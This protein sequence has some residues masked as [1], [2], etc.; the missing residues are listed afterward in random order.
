MIVFSHGNSFP[1]RTYSV[2]IESLR[3]RGFDVRFIEKFGHDPRFP[4]ADNWPATEEELS[5]FVGALVQVRQG[6]PLWLVGHS[7]GGLVSLMT[8]ARHPQW[9]RGVVL[10]D[11]PVLGGWK[12][13]AMGV[14][15]NIPLMGKF[16]PGAVSRKRRN[17]WPDTDAVFEHFRHKRAF[18]K[19][20]E[21]VL[22]DYVAYGT[23]DTN[24]KRVLSF[25]RE[26][27]TRFY[28]TVPDHLPAYLRRHPLKCPVTFIGGSDSVER[29]QVGMDMVLRITKGRTM[30]LDGSHLFPME[31]PLATAAAVEAA[32][33]NM[34]A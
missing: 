30:M 8:A 16:S 25:D 3:E 14:A 12:S 20:D 28:N 26:V 5:E 34:G 10:L 22:R 18:A 2:L 13:T 23:H 7:L 17:T 1:A 32:L 19:W 29:R 31:K 27:E 11:S 33:R 24:G 15:K 21:Q 4:V 6:Q 9:V